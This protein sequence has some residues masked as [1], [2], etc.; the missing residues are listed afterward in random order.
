M[1]KKT[2]IFLS[3][4]LILSFMFVACGGGEEET[5]QEPEPSDTT[6][7]TGGEEEAAETTD[8]FMNVEE[9]A[10]IVF[11]GWGDETEQQIYRDS[12]ERFAEVCPAVTV[13]YQPIPADFQTK[14][15][16][17]MA[18]G[19]A[20]DVFYIDDQLMTAFA[21]TGQLLPLDDYMGQAGVSRDDFEGQMRR[22]LHVAYQRERIYDMQD[23]DEWGRFFKELAAVV[24]ADL[25]G[26]VPAMPAL[27]PGPP[28]PRNKQEEGDSFLEWSKKTRGSA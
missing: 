22:E 16:A 17:S 1:S 7:E 10:T 18:G 24:E 27:A 3:L 2:I 20:A 11:S 8:C 28:S 19:T 4:L 12:I 23:P 26:H 14:L 6:T 9:G 25:G 5:T 15:K 21:P 13:D